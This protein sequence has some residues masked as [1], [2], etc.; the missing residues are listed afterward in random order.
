M[1]EMY[2]FKLIYID[3]QIKMNGYY[4]SIPIFIYCYTSFTAC[5][6]CSIP[7]NGAQCTKC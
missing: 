7:V 2:I 4:I 1:Y 6:L 3:K 5:S